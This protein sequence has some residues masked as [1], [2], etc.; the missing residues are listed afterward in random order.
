MVLIGFAL[1]LICCRTLIWQCLLIGSSPWGGF[2]K[3]PSHQITF[4]IAGS[5]AF[6]LYIYR[7]DLAVTYVQR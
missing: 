5:H 7:T 4:C 6:V 1:I 2:C 3:H